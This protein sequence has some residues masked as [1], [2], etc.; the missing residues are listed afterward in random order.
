VSQ[1][2]NLFKFNQNEEKLVLDKTF[3]N[4][5]QYIHN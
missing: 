5:L 4:M 2:K 1:A 3:A